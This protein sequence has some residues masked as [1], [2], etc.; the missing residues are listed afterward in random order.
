MQRRYIFLD[1]TYRDRTLYPQ[2]ADFTVQLNR[3]A[4]DPL[5][6]SDAVCNAM[7][8]LVFTDVFDFLAMSPTLHA[9]IALFVVNTSGASGT[10]ADVVLQTAGAGILSTSPNYYAGAVIQEQL[11][12]T[13]RRITSYS[14]LDSTHGYFQLDRPFADT[15]P[16]GTAVI[17]LNPTNMLDPANPEFFVPNEALTANNFYANYI[18]YDETVGDFRPVASYNPTTH[19]LLVDTTAMGPV[20]GWT[21]T[22]TFD[23]RLQAPQFRGAIVAATSTTVTLPAG[24]AQIEPGSWIRF[25]S[26]PENGHV[27]KIIN[28][29]PITLIVTVFPAMNPIPLPGDIAEILQFSYDNAVP[30]N[31]SG[32]IVSQEQSVCY[33]IELTA[34]ILPNMTLAVG[35]G[36]RSSFYPA[37]LVEFYDVE[38]PS[39]NILYTNNPNATRALFVAPTFDVQTP[40][41]TAFVKIDGG[42]EVQTVKFK[43]NADIHFRV[44]LLDGETFETVM[45]DTQPPSPP[46]P[47]VQIQAVFSI[48]R[49]ALTQN[50]GA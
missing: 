11:T 45:Q 12:L 41:L 33:E 42:G 21:P 1:S 3:G 14:F 49:A 18:L 26:G 20:V 19:I 17:I 30:M 40:L 43:P 7:P 32:S 15:V 37:F 34:L 28:F 46:N 23:L 44:S 8:L 25:T 5:L 29:D 36:S 6:A 10:N 2:P 13:T 50:S 27:F 39:K 47:L 35:R 31:Y 4:Q 48:K 22:D 38:D 24:A 16:V 9:T